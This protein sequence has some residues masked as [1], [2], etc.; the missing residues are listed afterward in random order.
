MGYRYPK[1]DATLKCGYGDSDCIICC[2]V[3]D[4][5][6]CCPIESCWSD[7]GIS[8]GFNGNWYCECCSDRGS[9]SHCRTKR[10]DKRRYNLR[11]GKHYTTNKNR[12]MKVYLSAYEQLDTVETVPST[13]VVET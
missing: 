6:Y 12:Q 13:V 1:L 4:D 2:A 7:D 3:G 5:G 9:N 11:A 8:S 10:V